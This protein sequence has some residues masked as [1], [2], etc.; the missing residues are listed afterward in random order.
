MHCHVAGA[1][2]LTNSICCAFVDTLRLT[3]AKSRC[4][5]PEVHETM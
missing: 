5:L 3:N 4:G 2:T 1:D